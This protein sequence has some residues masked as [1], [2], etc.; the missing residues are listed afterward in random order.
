MDLSEGLKD[1]FFSGLVLLTPL[2]ATF[3][4]ISFVL[5]WTSGLTGFFIDFFDLTS[6][7]LSFRAAAQILVLLVMAVIVTGIGVFGKSRTGKKTLG[8]FGKLVNIVPIYR[9]LYHG[10]KHISSALVEK[11]TGYNRPVLA[12]YPSE[13][14]YRIGFV[15]SECR[16]EIDEQPYTDHRSHCHDASGE[17]PGSRYDSERSFQTG[18]NNR[19]LKQEDR[20]YHA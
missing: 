12:E 16:P 11:Q 20:K 3:V 15:T 17:A 2:L 6:V 19:Y 9:S 13:D 14:I 5:G 7:T 8:G 18:C 1:S 10:I 4:I